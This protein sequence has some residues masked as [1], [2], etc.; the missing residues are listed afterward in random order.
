MITTLYIVGF[1][2]FLHG[3]YQL[4]K[5]L[6]VLSEVKEKF[7]TK[8]ARIVTRKP[9]KFFVLVPVLHEE[10]TIEKFLIDLSLQDYPNNSF[11]VCVIT[12]QK[13][14]LNR[15]QPNTIDILNRFISEKKFPELQLALIAKWPKLFSRSIML[16]MKKKMWQ[17][18]TP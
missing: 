4:L 11:E 1:L 14:Y 13:E 16:H 7:L 15:V 2:L 3:A 9:H 5:Y 17:A 6:I 12:T 10:K 8:S 18:I